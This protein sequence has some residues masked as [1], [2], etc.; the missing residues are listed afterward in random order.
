MERYFRGVAHF[1]RWVSDQRVD[2]HEVGDALIEGFLYRH[3]PHCDCASK[4]ERTR[5]NIRAGV[6]RFLD[7]WG[8]PCAN[9]ISTVSAIIAREVAD[10][11]RHLAEV[12]GLSDS[13]RDVQRRQVSEFF[14]DRFGTG[15]VNISKLT[16]A[17]VARFLQRRTRGLAPKSIKG[18]GI[19]L[20]SYLTFKASLGVP[21]T[22]LVAALPRVALWRLAGLPDILSRDEIQPLLTAFDR[23]NATGMRDYAITRCLL[24]LGLRRMEVAHLCLDDID[25]RAGTLTLHGKGRRIDV[26][27]LPRR[28]GEAIAAYLQ[29]GR[30][31]TT[32]REVFVRHRPPINAEAN[33][34]IVRNAVRYAAERCGFQQRVRGTHIFRHTMACQMTQGGAPFKEIADLLRHRSLDTTTIYVEVDVPSLRRVALP[35]PGSR[36]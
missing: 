31:E 9:A 16:P 1:V 26:V 14:V 19:S 13:T 32:R 11:D 30:P 33:L 20:R 10:F 25:W 17:D 24:D 23:N 35:W 34:E 29:H 7:M 15:T 36:S 8:V 5:T 12:R 22:A 4:C 18:I 27:P 3:L 28:T 6:G 21:T 2:F